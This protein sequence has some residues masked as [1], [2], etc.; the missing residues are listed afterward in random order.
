MPTV[1]TFPFKAGDILFLQGRGFLDNVINFFQQFTVPVGTVLF[2]HTGVVTSP[3]GHIFETT[4]WRT[5]VR[6]ISEAYAGS[7]I[8]VVRWAQLHRED[9]DEGLASV[10]AQNGRI[11]PYWRLAV[12]AVGLAHY[13][14]G[15][16]MECCVIAATFLSNSGMQLKKSPW[17]Y[18]TATLHAELVA[19]PDCSVVFSGSLRASG[20]IQEV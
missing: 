19:R 10:K 4:E 20:F 14:H 12:Q 9:F 15:E 17:A 8:E 18:N 2:S 3:F 11:Y 7:S 16:G 5:Q 13:L 6:K 1:T